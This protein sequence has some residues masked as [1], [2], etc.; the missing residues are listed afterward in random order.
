MTR[1]TVATVH[2]DA[3]Q[4]NLRQ[5]SA[6]V[7]ACSRPPMHDSTSAPQHPS[8]S[9][10][11]V[12]AV[13]K[14]NAYGH[15][16][17]SV[18][19][20]D[21]RA[22]FGHYENQFLCADLKSGSNVWTFRDRQFPYFSSPAVTPERVV[23]GGRDKML[24]CLNRADGRS[25]WSLATRGRVDSSPVVC[26]DKVVVGSDDGRVYLVRL[27]DGKELWSYE[28]GQPVGSSPAVADGKIVIGSDD[29]SV[30]CFGAKAEKK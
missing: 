10:P 17:A 13:V 7:L 11:S 4:H 16:A 15:G 30:Y 29:G 8:P 18:A 25:V 14:A 24:H 23:F 22:Y 9:A 3:L 26:G 2:L 28:I 5:I 27:S 1:P 12:I 20:A 19:L 6:L 21:G